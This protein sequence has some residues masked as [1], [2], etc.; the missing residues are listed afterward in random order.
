M[1]LGSPFDDPCRCI[2]GRNTVGS[3]H[4]ASMHDAMC[5]GSESKEASAAQKKGLNLKYL[6]KRQDFLGIQF[7]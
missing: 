5:S 7:R 1:L 3:E 6:K 2:D 4:A